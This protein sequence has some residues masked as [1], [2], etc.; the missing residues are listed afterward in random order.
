M[1][2]ISKI[3]I[4]PRVVS[5]TGQEILAS[6]GV[7]VKVS[8]AANFEIAD[9]YAAVNKVQ[10]YQES[11]YLTLQL[12]L[13][14]VVGGVNVD[15][16]LENRNT[17]FDSI[18]GSCKE[19]VKE[20]GLNLIDVNVKDIMSPGALKEMFAQVAKAKQEGQAALERARGEAAS[21]RSLAN[22]AK[23]LETNPKLMNLRLLQTISESGGNT[24]V[25]NASGL[26]VT[27]AAQTDQS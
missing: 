20:I 26:A 9:V 23:M 27:L 17:L 7:T 1:A 12:A 8:L 18:S 19:A 10:D 2:S 11:L 16:L 6:D 21:L 5:I 25:V 13:R 22:A 14:K 4:R 24:F 15:T 3:D